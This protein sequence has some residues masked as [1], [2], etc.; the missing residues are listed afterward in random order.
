MIFPFLPARIEQKDH[1]SGSWIN[2]AEVGSLAPI[3]FGAGAGQVVAFGLAFV[4]ERD[5]VVYLMGVG[6][7]VLMEQA[8]F[9]AALRSLNHETAQS[10]GD[11]W[12]RHGGLFGHLSASGEGAAGAGFEHNQHVA[13]LQ[14][15]VQF[16][17][18]GGGQ[19]G[20]PILIEQGFEPLLSRR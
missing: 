5:D 1:G 4:T 10:F 16:A 18:L 6:R 20:F 14:V 3:A 2:R 11:G 15:L 9:A 7:V 12:T 19:L 13:V 17:L 8:V